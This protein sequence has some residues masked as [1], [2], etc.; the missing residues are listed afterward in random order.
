MKL[1]QDEKYKT[2]CLSNDFQTY[3]SGTGAKLNTVLNLLSFEHFTAGEI[4]QEKGQLHR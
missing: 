4:L 2:V 3:L 1:Q